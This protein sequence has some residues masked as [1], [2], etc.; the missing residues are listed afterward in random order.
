MKT[1]ICIP[2]YAGGARLARALASIAPDSAVLETIVL[3][4]G[5]PQDAADEIARIARDSRAGGTTLIRALPNRG[6]IA[7]YRDLVAAASGEIV[8]M[9]DDDAV[10]PQGLLTAALLLFATIPN[11]GVLS[12]RSRGEKPGQSR[13]AVPGMLQ[14]ATQIAGYC[15]AF[16]RSV[17]DEIGGFDTRYHTYCADSDLALRATFAGFPC[18]RV[19]WPLVPHE[20]HGAWRDSVEL[21]DR[22]MLAAKDLA[23]FR[24]KW[25]ADGEEMEKRALSSLVERASKEG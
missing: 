4:D 21:P 6:P 15:M 17:Y 19:W 8:L 10:L 16:R 25:G 11:L 2:T 12:W 24:S 7:A 23:A 9:M 1:S 18:Y 22:M 14:P 5:S 3:D 20:E 13:T